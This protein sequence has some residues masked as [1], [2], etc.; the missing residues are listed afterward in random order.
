MIVLW[1]KNNMSKKIKI[2]INGKTCLADPGQNV[3]EVALANGQEIPHL[4]FHPDLKIQG[5]CRLCQVKI[6]GKPGLQSAC[7]LS[8]QEGLEV[9]SEAS[10]ARRARAVNLELIFTEHCEECRDCIYLQNC[11]IRHY[12]KDWKININKFPD[13]K[14]G[15]PVHRFGPAL[16]FDSSKCVDC[17]LCVEACHK[18]GVDFLEYKKH[19]KF[20]EVMPSADPC[21]DCIYCG[22]CLTHCPVG[23]FEGVGEFEDSDLVFERP[24]KTVVWQFAPSVR[25]TI[26][27]EFGLPYGTVATGRL[28]SALK[29]LGVKYVFDTSVGADVTTIEEAKEL[30]ERIKN[31]KN[32]P[33]F[34]SCC[35]GW[36]KYVEFFHPELI[37]YLTST[38]SPQMIM[39]GLIKTY[40]AKKMKLNPKDIIVVSIMPC[41]AKKYEVQRAEMKISG[42]RAV[43]HVYTVREAAHIFRKKGIDLKTMPESKP[44]PIF[45]QPTGAG[46]IYGASGGVMESALR[47]AYKMI[48]GRKLPKI[49]F[50]QVRGIQGL[51]KA[52]IKVKDKIVKVAVAN[53]IAN[54]KVIIAELK[55]NPGAYDYVEVMACFGGC[56]GGGGQPVP[57]D[58]EIRKKRAAGLYS[59]D[60]KNKIRVAEDSP[61]VQDVYKNFLDDEKNA[62]SV[63]HTHYMKKSKEVYPVKYS[64]VGGVRRRR[65]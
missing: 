65:I 45:A 5:S 50:E 43:D 10:D 26:G 8:V 2:I 61:I 25:T 48:T 52:D 9:N 3:L 7:T 34:T 64:A 36:V 47:T 63:C 12:A 22:Q 57:V 55:K 60:T 33:L 17:G 31:K 14:A 51:K 18:V 24:D 13:R 35:P 15:Y 59:I 28:I 37:P 38:R 40:W 32:L 30:I 56:I 1:A 21:H 6:K 20:F 19:G 58:D 27:E 54:A 46:V 42:L 16:E 62:K 11:K 44:D 29:K 23:A 41:V 4:C 39:A 49:E 53:G